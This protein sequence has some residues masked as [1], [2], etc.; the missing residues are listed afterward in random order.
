M[1]ILTYIISH[2]IAEKE[3]S[4]NDL[5][6]KSIKTK[7]DLNVDTACMHANWLLEEVPFEIMLF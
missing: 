1:Y 5:P 6:V 2:F 3:H 4:N 7:N